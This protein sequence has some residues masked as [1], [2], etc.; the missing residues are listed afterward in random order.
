MPLLS[1]Q[2][3]FQCDDSGGWTMEDPR[4]YAS[5]VDMLDRALLKHKDRTACVSLGHSLTYADIDRMATQWASWLTTL[6]LPAQSRVAI[7][8]PN[9]AASLVT[10]LGTLRAG[11]VV[12]NVNPLYTPRELA[13]QLRDSQS[14]V[15]VVFEA[16]AHT[17]EQ[18][19]KR[20][21]PAHQVVVRAGDLLPPLKAR[22]VNFVV[23]HVKRRVPEWSLPQALRL[24]QA[25]HA[26]ASAEVGF[27]PLTAEDLAFIQYTGG[28]T[29][30]PKGAMLTHGNMVANIL[31]VQD[32]AQP[33]L[34]GLL[35]R[36]LTMLTAL[37]LYHVFA[38]TVCALYALHAGMKIVLVLNARDL[39]SL[40]KIWRAH[41]PAIFPG[42]NTLFNALLRHPGF[43]SLD[44]SG[45]CL[46]LGGGM[47]V[48]EAVAQRWQEL[49]GRP[50][51]QG[52]GMSETSPVICA[53][54][55]D[56]TSFS[57]AV[58]L[59]LPM[60]E[61]QILDDQR[62]PVALGEV[63][64]I[65]V[66]GP[67][68]MRG[69]WQSEQATK[70]S[71]TE[72]GFFLTGDLGRL[73]DKGFVTIVDRKKDMVLVS[74]FNVYPSEIDAVFAEHP[75]VL[76]CAAV[77]FPDEQSG[78]VIR[79]FVVSRVAD[80]DTEALKRWSQQRLTPYKRPRDF[81]FVDS[82]PKNAVGKT[83]RRILRDQYSS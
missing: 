21:Q 83:L 52:Y 43:R 45:L 65:A 20:D 80:V 75:D 40:V 57:G 8:L 22:I 59:P 48:H 36:S 42:V 11:H 39:D 3:E 24:D 25:L 12:V 16:F 69:Y 1:L 27:A 31:Q 26:G 58:G 30:E 78:E 79:L 15:I 49:T 6:G 37:P 61:V 64:E 29:G 68:V 54:P 67:Q 81:V 28:T 53:N 41:P 50:I 10:L 63:G 73:D 72:D 5:L 35:H 76:E 7:M 51:I 44:F 60:T 38:M 74:G 71:M 56:A 46:T 55:T 19:P 14:S 2:N 32:V 47:A 70:A 9:V 82:L 66:R 77:G 34:G 13:A 4:S 17:L 33:A 23:K 18:L 62:Q